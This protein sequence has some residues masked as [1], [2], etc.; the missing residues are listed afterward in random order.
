[1]VTETEQGIDARNYVTDEVLRDG[2][3]VQIRAIRP[4]DKER[5]LEHFAGLGVSSRYFR[6]FGNKRALTGEDLIRF[7]ELDFDRHVGLA[8]TV[9]RNQH[10]RF[11]AVGRYIRTELLAHAEIAVAVLDEYQGGGIGPLLIHHLAHI[12]HANGITQFEADVLGDNRRMLALLHNSGCIIHHANAGG[13]VHFTLQCPESHG[14][15]K[16]SESDYT[17]GSSIG[18]EGGSRG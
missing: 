13:V 14:W 16:S 15:V 8:A 9:R 7:T 12:A 17:D 2:T 10:E 5:L 11:I 1:M 3:A 18:P 6:F 4:D